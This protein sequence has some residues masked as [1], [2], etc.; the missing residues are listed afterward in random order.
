M[1]DRLLGSACEGHGHLKV[2][3]VVAKRDG[4]VLHEIAFVH[5][6]AASDRNLNLEDVLV[7]GVQLTRHAHLLE[8]IPNLLRREVVQGEGALQSVDSGLHRPVLQVRVDDFL[9]RLCERVARIVVGVHDLD[10]LHG[11]RLVA[12]L[13]EHGDDRVQRDV[14]L[15]KIGRGHLYEDILGLKTDLGVLAVD[16][17]RHRQHRALAVEDHRIDG[18][19]FDDGQVSLQLLVR[20]EG[21]HQPVAVHLLR[22]IERHELDVLGRQRLVGEGRRQGRE[23][24]RT[25]GA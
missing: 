22:L 8:Q 13:R 5:D 2:Q 23:V 7:L 11:E 19:V 9:P 3:V 18:A 6:V 15:R 12:V 21:L 17:R 4:N 10:R 25:Y 1:V 24:V 20:R 16:D 14:R